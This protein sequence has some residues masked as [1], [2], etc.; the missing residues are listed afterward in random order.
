VSSAAHFAVALLPLLVSLTRCAALDTAHCTVD[1]NMRPCSSVF[2]KDIISARCRHISRHRSA[3][4]SQFT[5]HR[6]PCL[7]QNICILLA[8]LASAYLAAAWGVIIRL[9]FAQ[10][11]N[12]HV[13]SP[14]THLSSTHPT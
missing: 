12:A 10:P 7:S 4:H 11:V 1:H 9:T 2:L 3:R 8:R 13:A 6:C 14:P 5:R